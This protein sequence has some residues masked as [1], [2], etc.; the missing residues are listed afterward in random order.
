LALETLSESLRSSSKGSSPAVDKEKQVLA[1]VRSANDGGDDVALYNQRAH[2][3]IRK[4]PVGKVKVVETIAPLW[5]KRFVENND[6]GGVP[7]ELR[8]RCAS[9]NGSAGVRSVR[10]CVAQEDRLLK[11]DP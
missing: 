2:G 10:A 3:F 7:S 1:L 4:E 11:G 8:K 6:E 9:P 5:K